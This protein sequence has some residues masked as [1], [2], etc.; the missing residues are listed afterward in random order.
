MKDQEKSMFEEYMGSMAKIC[1]N[2]VTAFNDDKL[3]G[4]QKLSIYYATLKGLKAT[5]EKMLRE[6]EG[7]LTYE[8]RIRLEADEHNN[9]I[10][11]N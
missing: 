1:S 3:S 2:S 7:S 11:I 9:T 5:S 4:F 10:G 6:F 8:E